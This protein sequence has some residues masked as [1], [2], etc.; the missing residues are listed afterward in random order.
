MGSGA[1]FNIRLDAYLKISWSREIGTLNYCL[2]IYQQVQQQR[3]R[4]ACQIS[5]RSDIY[6]YKSR[7]YRIDAKSDDYTSY[8]I[9]K[10]IVVGLCSVRLRNI[11]IQW[12]FMQ[13]FPFQE[14]SGHS[15]YALSQSKM[16]SQYNIVSYWPSAYIEWSLEMLV[17]LYRPLIPNTE[18]YTKHATTADKTRSLVLI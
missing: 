16:T 1:R 5:K 12:Q 8:L 2:E 11:N 10:N 6:I 13:I 4:G 17:K 14:I 9:L 18:V 7:G 3:Y 15:G